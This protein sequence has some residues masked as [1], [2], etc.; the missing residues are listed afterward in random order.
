MLKTNTE[1]QIKNKKLRNQKQ[2]QQQQQQQ[3]QHNKNNTNTYLLLPMSWSLIY[4]EFHLENAMLAQSIWEKFVLV[5]VG[6]NMFSIFHLV[7]LWL[8]LLFSGL[9]C[10]S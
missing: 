7:I 10:I 5:R 1:K 8:P 6:S 3:Q 2:Q 4:R 9:F